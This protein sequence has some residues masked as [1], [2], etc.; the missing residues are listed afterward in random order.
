MI[1]APT[2][3]TD[4]AGLAR[5]MMTRE[6][7][8]AVRAHPRF[9]EAGRRTVDGWA[10]RPGDDLSKSRALQDVGLFAAGLWCM[11]LDASPAGLTH[12]SLAAAISTWG[13]ASRGRVGPMLAYL[14]FR[15]MIQLAPSSDR[16]VTRYTPTSHLRIQFG[17][18]FQR[19]L[20]GAAPI[21]PEAEA[22]LARWGE[23]GLL[24]RLVTAYSTILLASQQLADVKEEPSLDVF[25]HRRAGLIILG[26]ILMAADDGG[27]FPPRGPVRL[28]LSDLARRSAASRGQV[29]AVLREG[30]KAGFLLRDEDGLTLLSDNLIRHVSDFLP[31][32]WMALAWAARKVLGDE[33]S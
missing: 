5:A 30:A 12:S 3:D 26:Q 18:W 13:L 29:Q 16:R 19:E 33:L 27:A 32:Y 2:P 25:S 11:Q 7:I 10:P 15:N 14:R 9:A 6:A 21:F 20:E 28:V 8:D 1:V 23:P 22:L 4:I 24:E 31:M 17:L